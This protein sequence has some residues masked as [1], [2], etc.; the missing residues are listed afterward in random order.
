MEIANVEQKRNQIRTKFNHTTNLITVWDDWRKIQ[1]A[2]EHLQKI[3]EIENF[4][5]SGIEML[6]RNLEKIDELNENISE[7][8]ERL[9]KNKIQKS[10]I[11][12]DEKL[13][14]NK[15]KILELQKGQ[16]KYISAVGDLPALEEKLKREK[17]DLK[18]LLHEIGPDWNE[19]KLSNFDISIPIK[20]TVRK[21]H[22]TLEEARE[23]IRDT[24]KELQRIEQNIKNIEEEIDEVDKRLKTHSLQEVDEKKL[25]Q[26]RKSLRL[27]REKYPHLKEKEADIRSLCLLL[28]ESLPW[29]YQFLGITG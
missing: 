4:P 11:K 19:E 9:E 23:K 21:K 1:E 7:K 5:E 29:H 14:S 16:D 3:P 22:N 24:E 13:L 17:E 12:I 18:E 25:K 26:Q 6:E 2:K 10:Q 28:L 15:E 8:N 20:E 27:L